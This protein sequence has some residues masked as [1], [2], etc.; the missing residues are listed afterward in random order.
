L[1]L[2]YSIYVMPY[3]ITYML[4]IVTSYNRLIIFFTLNIFVICFSVGLRQAV[5]SSLGAGGRKDRNAGRNDGF[6][7]IHFILFVFIKYNFYSLHTVFIHYIIIVFIH[8]KL[9]LFTTYL[10]HIV[11]GYYFKFVDHRRKPPDSGLTCINGHSC[12]SIHRRLFH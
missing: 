10:L 4:V 8:Y 9:L 1:G 11:F 2:Y 5:D 7:F 12:K 6:S 3:G